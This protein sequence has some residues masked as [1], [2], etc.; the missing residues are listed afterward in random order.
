M[1]PSIIC[2]SVAYDILNYLDTSMSFFADPLNDFLNLGS[3]NDDFMTFAY[4]LDNY[5]SH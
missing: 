3:D 5:Y 1:N 2:P 4:E